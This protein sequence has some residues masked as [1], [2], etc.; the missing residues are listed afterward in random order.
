[1]TI[2]LELTNKCNLHCTFC[3]REKTPKT[4]FISRQDFLQVIQRV[5]E[6]SFDLAVTAC[7]LGDPL[8]HPLLDSFVSFASAKGIA[9]NVNTSGTLLTHDMSKKLISAG[10]SEMRFSVTGINESYENYYNFPF[11]KLMKQILYFRQLAM[12]SGNVKLKIVV[13]LTKEVMGNLQNIIS[14][15]DINGISINDLI[16]LEEHNRAGSYQSQSGELFDYA[17][18]QKNFVVHEEIR[19]SRCPIPF[20]YTFIGW[21]GRYY[22]CALD[23]EKRVPLGHVSQ[24]SINDIMQI[25]LEYLNKQKRLCV[26]CS[27]LPENY[28]YDVVNNPLAPPRQTLAI[29]LSNDQKHQKLL[30]K[31][32]GRLPP[33]FAEA[34]E[35]A[36]NVGM[37]PVVNA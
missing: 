13:V 7:G 10:L 32:L 11:D 1:M 3:P 12:E 16:F 15:W 27:Y 4:G 18:E 21:D 8:L 34:I 20:V 24:Q 14:F 35:P 30:E 9:F 31:I 29:Y 25:K 6:S 37:I 2:D 22:L 26:T 17:P 33:Y 23:W 5:E 19:Q 28:I 36:S